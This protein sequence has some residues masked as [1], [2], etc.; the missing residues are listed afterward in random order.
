MGEIW[1][2]MEFG[3]TTL[4]VFSSFLTIFKKF[5]RENPVQFQTLLNGFFF[6]GPATSAL[7]VDAERRCSL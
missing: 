6:K 4:T 7:G 1:A 3:G 5:I 2:N